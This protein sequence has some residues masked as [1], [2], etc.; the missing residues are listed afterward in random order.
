[1]K[2]NIRAFAL[3]CGIIW[4]V[5][6]FCLTWWIMLFEGA[7]HKRTCIGHLY[8][9]YNISPRGSVI[10]LLWGFFDALTGGALF[11]WMY[12]LLTPRL[13]EHELSTS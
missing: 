11:A 2:I 7:T 5:G 3:S 6:L 10:G 9:G 1:M 13:T 4:G 8:R 12:N